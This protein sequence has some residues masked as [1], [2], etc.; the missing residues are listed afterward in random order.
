MLLWVIYDISSDSAR[1]KMA[2]SCESYGLYRVQYSAFLGDVNQNQMDELQ[3][4]A[5]ELINEKSDAVY[6][7]PMCEEDFKKVALVGQ[8][9]DREL[10]ADQLSTKMI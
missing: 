6:L 4:K 10:I 9:F 8:E 5:K 3:L 1:K 2:D 7:F